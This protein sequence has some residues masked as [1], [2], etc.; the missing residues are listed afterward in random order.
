MKQT[1]LLLTL[2]ALPACSSGSGTTIA[3]ASPATRGWF[4]RRPPRHVAY[5]NC[6]MGSHIDPKGWLVASSAMPP[7]RRCVM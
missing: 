2:A 5:V 4:R 7:R 3:D 6:Q 1:H